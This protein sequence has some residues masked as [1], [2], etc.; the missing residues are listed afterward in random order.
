VLA[1]TRKFSPTFRD[2]IENDPTMLMRDGEFVEAAL[3]RTRVSR[4]DVMA[5]L[6]G[7]NALDLSKV[8]AVVLETTGDIS[9][10]HGDAVD[11]KIIAGVEIPGRDELTDERLRD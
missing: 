1:R 2:T 7:A 6:R 4:A 10:L 5:K 11:P 3:K 8:R 9:V